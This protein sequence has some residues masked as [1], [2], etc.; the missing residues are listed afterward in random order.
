M[1]LEVEKMISWKY[2]IKGANGT[3]ITGNSD[4]AE[5]KSKLGYFVFC[6]SEN[7]INRYIHR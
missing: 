7:S 3:I 4:Y 1:K 5:Q 6:K 2:R